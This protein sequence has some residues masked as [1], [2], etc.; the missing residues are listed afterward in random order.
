MPPPLPAP[1]QPVV[2]EET[3]KPYYQELTQFL[4]KERR[5]HTIFPPKDEVFTALELTPYEQVRV[6]LLG[7][8]PYPGEGQAHGLAFSVRPGVKLPQSLVNIF[9]ELHDDLGCRIPNNGYLAPWAKQGVLLLN[10]VLTVR[11]HAPNSH[12]GKG[13]EKVTDAVIRKVNDRPDPVVFLLWG[14]HAQKKIKLIDTERHT[15]VQMAHP[16]PLSAH[17]G[18]F[19]SKPFAQVNDALRAA[20][21]PPIDWQLPD[22]EADAGTPAKPKG[23]RPRKA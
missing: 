22:V 12:K 5:E 4:D 13:W 21:K 23:R 11:A 17:N 15:I 6:L 1:W 10:T 8:D 19:G 18:F 14:G 3:Q 9:K 7:Q 16:S 20:G 2:G